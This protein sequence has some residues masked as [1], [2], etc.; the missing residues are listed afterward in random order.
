VVVTSGDSVIV[1]GGQDIYMPRLIAEVERLRRI[2]G[3]R[4]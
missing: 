3:N 1:T 2:I 4:R